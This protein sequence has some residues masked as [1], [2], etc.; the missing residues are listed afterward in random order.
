MAPS[1]SQAPHPHL[2]TRVPTS[3]GVP[4][5]RRPGAL[6]S[7]PPSAQSLAAPSSGFA[8]NSPVH[9]NVLVADVLL[10]GAV[11]VPLVYLDDS[12]FGNALWTWLLQLPAED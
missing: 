9:R 12:G 2:T 1:A 11:W 8:G 10:A 3:C 4:Y 5:V 7:R 6:P